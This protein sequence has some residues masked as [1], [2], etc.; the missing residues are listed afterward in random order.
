VADDLTEEQLGFLQVIKSNANRLMDLINDI[1]D[2][3]RF[4]SGKIVL[5]FAPVDIDTVIYEVEQTLRLEARKK[6]MDVHIDI[7]DGLP[8]VEADQKRLTQVV[9]NLFSNA[10][11]Y[12]FD[13]GTVTVRAFLNPAQLMQIEVEDSGVG[14]SQEQ[15]QKLFRPF[16]RAFN[17]LSDR[18]GGTGLGLS[19]A[20]SLVE[21]HGGEMWVNSEPGKGSTFSVVLPLTQANNHAQAD[22]DNE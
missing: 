5:N 18:S 21:L 15:L 16:Y 22:E 17:P 13:E 4:E 6:Q 10:I 11:K 2:I 20:R 14:M 1:L 8:S 7:A 19:I 3:S 12:T 9:T